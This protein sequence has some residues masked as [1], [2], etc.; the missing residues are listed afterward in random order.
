MINKKIITSVA[1]AS[2][3]SIGMLSACG[4]ASDAEQKSES[5]NEVVN[6]EVN[7]DTT[8]GTTEETAF[9][10]QDFEGFYCIT[11]TEQIEDYEVT[12]TNGYLFN[13]DGTGV[14]YGQD[15]IDITWNETEIHFADSTRPFTMEPGKLTVDDVT[16]DKI[17]GNFI[18]PYTCD[19][20]TDNLANG[21]Y[22]VEID[23][24]DIS[25]AD[26]KTTVWT[27]IFTEDSYDIVDI[28]NMA[29]GD[30]IFINGQL[31]P[32][33]SVER[34]EWGIININGGLENLG[35]AL[36]ADDESNCFVFAGMDMERSYTLQGVTTLDVS[37]NVKL[38]DNSDPSETK[39]YTGNDALLAL[40]D[41]LEK[42]P[43]NCNDCSI[44]VEDGAIVEIN[45]RYVP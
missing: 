41:M 20:D 30:V 28:K 36:V 39:E 4:N 26:G 17:E 10:L 25:E 21:I 43:L 1:V 9:G 40:K 34:T 23:K 27:G 8:E 14:C 3:I 5:T 6:E 37:D 32:V 11:T 22:Y 29:E 2:I 33:S 16:Y 13:G 19:V 15:V 31:M 38:I 24:S 42:Y 44:L 45:R 35:S 7:S 18:A 12:Y